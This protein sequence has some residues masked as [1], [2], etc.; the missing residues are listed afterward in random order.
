MQKNEGV[1]I[2]LPQLYDL[3]ELEIASGVV[4]RDVLHH[5]SEDLHIVGQQSFLHVVA[6]QVA[7]DAA[8]I[9]VARI[10]QE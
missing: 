4:I 10:A 6:E 2:E 5:A 1:F 3:I 8:E 9:F 7:E